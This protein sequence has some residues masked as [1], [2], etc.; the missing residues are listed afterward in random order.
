MLI[1]GSVRF[2][3]YQKKV[4][5]PKYFFKKNRNQFKLTGF[6]SVRFFRTKTGS[7]WFGLFFRFGSVLARFFADLARFFSVWVRFGFFGFRLIKPKL[8]WPVFFKILIGLIGFFSR[9]D[10]FGYFFSGFLSFLGFF[11][12]PYPR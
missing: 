4:T 6:V 1:F 3:F 11:A 2:G 10:F 7:N 9:F 5:K 8:N 12:H